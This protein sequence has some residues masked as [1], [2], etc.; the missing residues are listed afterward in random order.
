MSLVT[1]AKIPSLGAFL[2]KKTPCSCSSFSIQNISIL[3]EAVGGKIKG[4]SACDEEKLDNLAKRDQQKS[5]LAIVHYGLSGCELN[6][7]LLRLGN[8]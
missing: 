3:I 7:V 2:K 6:K 4:N 5:S 1:F 8:R